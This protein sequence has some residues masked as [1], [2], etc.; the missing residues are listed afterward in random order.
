M[1]DWVVGRRVRGSHVAPLS[2]AL[3]MWRA[4]AL[5]AIP[6]A[7][8]CPLAA[9]AQQFDSVTTSVVAPGVIHKRIVVSSGP[10]HVNVLQVDLKRPTISIHGMRAD[11]S[12]RGRETVRSMAER[13]RGPGEAVAAVNADF[14]DIKATGESENNVVVEGS[15]IK[16]VKRTD[17]PYDT[18]DNLH[19]QFAVDWRDHPFIDRFAFVGRAIDGKSTVD[20]DGLNFWPDSN[21]VALYT[22]PFGDSTPPD[23]AGRHPLSLVLRSMGRRGDTLLFRIQARPVDHGGVSLGSGAVLAAGGNRRGELTALARRGGT[24]KV[25]T[26]FAPYR[27]RL[28]TLLGGWP[29]LI[30]DGKSVAE[31]ADIIEGTFPRFSSTRHPRT[32][33]GFS[34]DSATLFLVTVDGRRESDSGMSL[35]ELAHL[36]LQLGVYQGMNF[37]GGGSTTMVVNDKVVNSP[38]DSSGDRAVGSALLV[39]VQ[40]AVRK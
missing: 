23:S 33:I 31:Q 6:A 1:S 10:W 7:A 16:G 30:V 5:V 12:F 29:G 8:G 3:A 21:A 17:S 2:R 35:V 28:R 22:A 18:F 40:L 25:V 9:R 38:S 34:R 20:L 13:Y 27:G 19:S 4:L 15:V 26:R 11:D 32:A 36:M 37:D 39:V 24:V 14:F